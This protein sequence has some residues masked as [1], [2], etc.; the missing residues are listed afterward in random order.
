VFAGEGGG[1]A[2][3]GDGADGGKQCGA[4]TSMLGAHFILWGGARRGIVEL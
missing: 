1:E 3:E 2:R 4:E